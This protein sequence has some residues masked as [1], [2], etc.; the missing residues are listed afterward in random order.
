M[1]NTP[2]QPYDSAPAQPRAALAPDAAPRQEV[3]PSRN[4]SA[5]APEGSWRTEAERLRLALQDVIHLA[6]A[7]A[8]PHAR[9]IKMRRRAQA[10]LSH[11]DARP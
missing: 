5:P 2:A 7:N 1:L 9:M 8:D 4:A 10:A 3:P 11:S 6:D